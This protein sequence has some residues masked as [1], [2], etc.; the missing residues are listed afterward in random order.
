MFADILSGIGI[1]LLAG[2]AFMLFRAGA[3]P[4]RRVVH[5]VVLCALVA[6]GCFRWAYS[7]QITEALLD[8]RGVVYYA[9]PA[10]TAHV[11]DR[12]GRVVRV[13]Y[14]Y[15]VDQKKYHGAAVLGSVYEKNRVFEKQEFVSNCLVIKVSKAN[16][17][18]NRLVGLAIGC[19]D[20]TPQGA[21][22]LDA[23]R[24]DAQGW[25]GQGG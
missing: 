22:A 1:L 14:E 4:P 24:I 11:E 10:H 23:A 20:F 8:E 2:A 3:K 5:G 19:P 6:F 18:L 15:G 12:T 16:P 25:L 17:E 9:V 7:L 21:P 13:E